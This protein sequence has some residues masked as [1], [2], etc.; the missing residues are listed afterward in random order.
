MSKAAALVGIDHYA[1]NPL[2]GC[3]AD[4]TALRDMLARNADDSANFQH[5]LLVS[6]ETTINKTHV[7]KA[8]T[9]IFSIKDAQLALFYFAGHGAQTP[10]GTY[11]V[12]Q[13][14][15]SY[16]EGVPMAQLI[17]AAN[18]SPSSERIIILDCC[19]AG[20]IDEFFGT[21]NNIALAQGV[22]ILAACRTEQGAAER[23][24]RG[25]FTTLVCDAL[26]GGAA[27]VRGFVNVPGIYAYVDE[28]LTLFDQ[29]PLMKANV[30]K[31]VPV[32]RANSSVSDDKLR[33]LIEYFS[34]PDYELPLDPSFEPTAPPSNPK[35]EAIFGDLQRYRGARLVVPNGEEH[36][37]YAAMN[38][39][40]C[41]LTPLGVYYW[42]MA[43]A[44]KI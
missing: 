27:D 41:S 29:R 16:D 7:A 38:K 6:S 36:L 3:V 23:N 40:S 43:K 44:G 17:A 35:N 24:N 26:N 18:E 21:K 11:L 10:S 33:K 32:R 22:S 28:V 9:E 42:K 14:A 15:R 39:K 20:G 5:Q 25:L 2:S 13:D 19:H 1:A 37:Y 34:A 12:T 30:S 4:A 31:L 8:F